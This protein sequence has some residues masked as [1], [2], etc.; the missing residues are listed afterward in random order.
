MRFYVPTIS[1]DPALTGG[2]HTHAAYS[3]R[4]RVGDVVTVFDGKGVE[5]ECK[6]TDIK[7]DKTLLKIIDRRENSGEKRKN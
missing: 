6:V 7:K 5:Y 4:I 1:E 2:T 3:L